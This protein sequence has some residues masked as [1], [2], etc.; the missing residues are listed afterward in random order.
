MPDEP[1]RL[2]CDQN[3]PFEA[4]VWLR[5]TKPD[6]RIWHASEVGLRGRPDAE[7]FLWAQREKAVVLTYDEDFADARLFPLGQHHGVIRLRV[8]PTT[9]EETIRG[10]ERLFASVPIS[11]IPQ[12]L[13][14]IDSNRIRLRRSPGG[15]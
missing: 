8:W 14:I 9:V 7:V 10:C 11:D 5:N 13:I 1:L 4:T 6:W 3:I 12:S 15:A 2:L